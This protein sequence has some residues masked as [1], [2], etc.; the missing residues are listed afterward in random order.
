MTQIKETKSEKKSPRTITVRKTSAIGKSEVDIRKA[1]TH[2]TNDYNKGRGFRYAWDVYP[3]YWKDTWG[4]VPRLGTVRADSAF[5]AER[6]A[7]DKGLLPY[8]FTFGPKV[9]KKLSRK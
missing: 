7:Y 1:V 2:A 5:D 8:N 6:A 9:V 4:E 3:D